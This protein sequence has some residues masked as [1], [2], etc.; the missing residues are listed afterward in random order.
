MNLGRWLCLLMVLTCS[1]AFALPGNAPISTKIIGQFDLAKPERVRFG[2]L[3]FLSGLV[4]KSSNR[5]FGGL[6]A[7][8]IFDNDKVLAVTDTGFWFSA[9]LMHDDA[10][11]VSGFEN[12][13]LSPILNSEGEPFISKWAV[14]AEGLA[15]RQ[16]SVFV[17]AEQDGRI[18]GFD[19]SGELFTAPS[20]VIALWALV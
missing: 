15:V 5:H 16:N 20:N 1:H 4:L 17:S 12:G 2:K 18:L 19:T 7:L 11:N 14:D 10:G 6:S 8:R 3:V 13:R 9:K